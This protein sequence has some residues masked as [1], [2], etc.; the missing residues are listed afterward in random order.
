MLA[1]PPCDPPYVFFVAQRSAM[2][3]RD[4][5]EIIPRAAYDLVRCGKRKSL[6]NDI[7][8]Q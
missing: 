6:A 5:F 7:N 2:N 1:P 8:S 3:Q 4:Q